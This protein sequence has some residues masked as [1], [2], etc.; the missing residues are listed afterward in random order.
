MGRLPVRQFILSSVAVFVAVGIGT[1]FVVRGIAADFALDEATLRGGSFAHLAV[2]PL[3]DARVRAGDPAEVA[4]LA[5]VLQ[6]RITE[7]SIVHIKVWSSS[8]QVLWSDERD[9]VGRTFPLDEDVAR[10]VGTEEVQ[11]TVS[12]LSKAEN[13]DERTS[14]PLLEVYSGGHD[15]DGVPLVMESYWSTDRM[16]AEQQTILVRTVAVALSALLLLQL[17]MVPFAVGLARR[18][19]RA[20]SER[21]RLV[22]RALAVSDLERRRIVSDLHDGLI[23]D[24]SGIG[25]ALPT[26]LDQ[27]PP[28]NQARHLITA[29]GDQ[30]QQDIEALRSLMTDIYPADLS[31]GGLPEALEDLSRQAAG[32]GL[33]VS[34][35]LDA[36]LSEAPEV[37]RMVYRVVREGLRNVAKHANTSEA[38]VRAAIDGDRATVSVIDHGCGMPVASAQPGHLGLQLLSDTLGDAGGALRTFAGDAGGTTMMA[39]FP[40]VLDLEPAE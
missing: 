15:A 27:L 7:G 18:V 36:A 21:A 34:I 5:R 32:S 23:Q 38:W 10:L 1:I 37:A 25:Y 33:R 39:T 26:V 4:T 11:A 9:L 30:L 17:V 16:M 6:P 24:L 31:V 12:D 8:G 29:M 28:D 20:R 13:I 3:V 40:L 2:A 19:D 14:G 35:D 22:R